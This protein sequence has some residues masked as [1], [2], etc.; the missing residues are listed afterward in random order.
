M[1][2]SNT[3]SRH[4]AA[5]GLHL[6]PAGQILSALLDAQIGALAGVKP[7]LPAIEKAAELGADAL[8][9]GGRMGY[10]G[11]GSSG[12]MALA[13]SLELAGTFGLPPERTPMMFAGGADALLHM[14]GAAEDDP[15]LAVADLDASGLQAGDVVLILTAS[16]RT[17]YALTIAQEARARGITVVGFANVDGTP[18]LDMS[19]IAVLLQTGAEIVAG[20]TRMGAATAQKVALNMLSVLVGIRLGHVHDGYMVNL[21]ADNAKLVDRATRIVSN[22]A[23]VPLPV[24]EAALT[25]TQ[26]AV[27]PAILVAQGMDPERA[28][29]ELERTGGHLQPLLA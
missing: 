21:V 17:P 26:G 25:A 5:D 27:K 1:V 6:Q 20:S 2:E 8:A 9:R 11:A 18:L 13:D 19:D 14:K 15:R 28:A 24:A 4:P 22:L 16:G 12:L 10:A 23:S 29:A 3:E 7:A